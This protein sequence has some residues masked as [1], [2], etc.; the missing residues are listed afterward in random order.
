MRK[1]IENFLKGVV[2]GIAEIIPGVSGS[3]LALMMGIYDEFIELLYS[4]SKAGEALILFLFRKRPFEN[5][6]EKFFRIKLEFGIPLI[7]GMGFAFLAFANVL[8]YFILH[9]PSLVLTFFFGLVLSSVLIP[10]SRIGKL[11][12]LKL[13]AGAVSFFIFYKLLSLEPVEILDEPSLIYTFF[14]GAIAICAM[15]LPGVSGS[16][17]LLLL[18]LYEY[19][20]FAINDAIK[21]DISISRLLRLIILLTGII[22]GFIFFVRLLKWLLYRYEGILMSVLTGLMLASLKVLWP[23]ID[24]KEH[25]DDLTSYPKVAITLSSSD[26]II[27]IVLIALTIVLFFLI[28]KFAKKF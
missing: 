13:V 22:F 2:M 7:L 21:F 3:T 5:L 14:A 23:F 10:I 16:F 11:T 24:Q 19:V 27:S 28:K 6:K 26:H 9:Y 25:F 8:H 15:S 1:N 12:L 20:I 18:G 17:I 4:I